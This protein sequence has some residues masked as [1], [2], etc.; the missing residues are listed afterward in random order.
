MPHGNLKPSI[1]ESGLYEFASITTTSV[2]PPAGHENP[3]LCCLC[4]VTFFLRGWFKGRKQT[5]TIGVDLEELWAEKGNSGGTQESEKNTPNK[6]V[7]R[8]IFEG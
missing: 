7:L 5:S 3:G 2:R 4:F 8:G 1:V 6:T